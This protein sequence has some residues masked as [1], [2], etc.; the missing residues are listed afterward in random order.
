MDKPAVAFLYT[1]E[2]KTT[3]V[4]KWHHIIRK[5]LPL[6]PNPPWLFSRPYLR[7]CWK[8]VGSRAEL[9]GML[10]RAW[11]VS[12]YN[13]MVLLNRLFSTLSLKHLNINIIWYH[14][15]ILSLYSCLF[16]WDKAKAQELS[17][18]VYEHSTCRY[19]RLNALNVLHVPP[20]CFIAPLSN[21]HNMV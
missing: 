2:N 21:R 10:V 8:E 5:P 13:S 1:A 4:E 3:K 16:I 12:I 6:Y 14:H 15:S 17:I 7:G 11:R 18:Y 20:P 9:R 19:V